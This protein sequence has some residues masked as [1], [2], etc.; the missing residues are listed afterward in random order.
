MV[1][2]IFKRL[3]FHTINMNLIFAGLIA[4]TI[5]SCDSIL[6]V[7]DTGAIQ[8]GDLNSAEMV[9]LIVNGARSE[10][11]D[12]FI[13]LSVSAAIFSDEAYVDHTNIDWRNFA[14]LSF[15]DGNA[16][17][18][19]IYSDIQ[20]L[21]TSAED[22]I[23]RLNAIYDDPDVSVENINIGMLQVYAG[24]GY[25][26]LGENFCSAPVNLSEAFSSDELL[27]M[28]I[29]KLTAAI[30]TADNAEQAREDADVIAEIR[31]LANL[32]IARS[33]LQLGNND[34]AIEFAAKVP[35]DF[36]AISYYSENTTRE[37]NTWAQIGTPGS[38]QW[39]SVGID[40]Q[41]LDD[42]RVEHS[43]VAYDG[44]NGNDIFL[45]YK[46]YDFEGWD[47]GGGEDYIERSTNITFASGLEAQ[48][49][50]AEA[51]SPSA[52]TAAFVNERRAAGDQPAMDL[53]G[54]QVMEELRNQ[55]ARDFYLT[56]RRLG[57][58]RRYL[59]LYDVDGFPSGTYAVGNEVYGNARCFIIPLEEKVANP[60][61]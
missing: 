55:R 35:E 36:E 28:G 5:C 21:R 10:F 44:L 16:I 7:D 27:Q 34:Q 58:L 37:N 8:E 9:D 13:N 38:D 22:G 45:P 52:E 39:V 17:N 18:L 26:Y 30:S 54:N 46:A 50:I 53:S 23:E 11:Q 49:I 20:Q 31:N 4:I 32:G 12:T 42:P 25:I 2:F 3:N 48:Y 1:T 41:N 14:L 6:E 47:S 29:E 51:Q 24:Y 56:G 57:D 59:N 19:S 60:N 40:F 33:Y 61:L 43:I 15:D